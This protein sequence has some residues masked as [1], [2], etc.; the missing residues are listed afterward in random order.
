MKEPFFSIIVPVYNA[1]D[2]LDR[3][4][5]SIIKQQADKWE[6]IVVDD[7]STD[8]SADICDRFA[9]KDERFVVIHKKNEGVSKTRNCGLGKAR[10]SWLVFVDADDY[11]PSNALS[12]YESYIMSEKA[13]LYVTDAFFDTWKGLKICNN[14]FSSPK[15]FLCKLISS[16][17]P[18]VLWAKC[19][20]IE[21]I[22]SNNLLFDD[23]ITMGEDFLFL[24]DYYKHSYNIHY[25]NQCLYYW[26]V[27]NEHSITQNHKE[28]FDDFLYLYKEFLK[29]MEAIDPNKDLIDE[30]NMRLFLTIKSLYLCN[31]SRYLNEIET[32]ANHLDTKTLKFFDRLKGLLLKKHCYVLYDML[33]TIKLMT[34]KLDFLVRKI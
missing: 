26:Y 18:T 6:C 8:N 10:G 11:L 22:R 5:T 28:Y 30:R 13:D 27:G 4:L 23:S 31:K 14:T 12:E 20:S 15:E 3:C 34:D 9:S 29:K 2:Y 19:F 25:I 1:G 16:E 32:M 33:Y 21:I 7:G 17:S 24:L